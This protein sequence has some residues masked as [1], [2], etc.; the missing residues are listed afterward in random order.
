MSETNSPYAI[1][2][3]AEDAENSTLKATEN[4][5]VTSFNAD[6]YVVKYEGGIYKLGALVA[7]N[8][9][10][11]TTYTTVAAAL[12][13]AQSGD[14][15]EMLDNSTEATAYLMVPAGVTFDLK[16]H[17]LNALGLV[18][19]DTAYVVD[20][21]TDKTGL[22]KVA[23]TNLVI[24]SVDTQLPVWN[25]VDGYIFATMKMTQANSP[26]RKTEDSFYFKFKPSLGS[27]ELNTAYLANGATDNKLAIKVKITWTVPGETVEENTVGSQEFVFGD[28][29][30][31][32]AFDPESKKALGITVSGIKNLDDLKVMFIVE[33]NG[34]VQMTSKEYEV[35]AYQTNN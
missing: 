3:G 10:T 17:T 15:V 25:E 23:K 20:N 8:I 9:T 30:V 2:L 4:L 35:P 6:K 21:S 26:E 29:Y 33:F 32:K 19:F 13:A 7:Q 22:L 1:I 34:K 31:S 11:G 28:T 16:G 5:G 18:A 24:M 12:A 27:T 14:T